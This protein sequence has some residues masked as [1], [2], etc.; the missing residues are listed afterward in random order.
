MTPFGYRVFVTTYLIAW[1]T[2]V[3]LAFYYHD[4][5]SWIVSAVT[6]AV[7]GAMTPDLKSIRR[8]FLSNIQLDEAMRQE[9]VQVIAMLRKKKSD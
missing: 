1:A 3:V 6:V 2:L 9:H 7:L 4:S 8:L 5:L